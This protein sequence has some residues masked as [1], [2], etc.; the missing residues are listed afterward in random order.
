MCE[1]PKKSHWIGFRQAAIKMSKAH[2]EWVL[3]YKDD[4]LKRLDAAPY[5][6]EAVQKDAR[7][8]FYD[9]EEADQRPSKYVAKS[10]G[11]PNWIGDGLHWLG[12]TN[13]Y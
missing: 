6:L 3:N 9:C 11:L 7:S 8:Y 13:K 10:F 2:N 12:V 5:D 1:A 4:G